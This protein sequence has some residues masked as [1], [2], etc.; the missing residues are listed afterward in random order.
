[1]KLLLDEMYSP[2]IAENL[3]D[4]GYDV[5]SAHERDDLAATDDQEIFRLMQHE[6][7]VIVTNNHRDFAPLAN[8]AL[9]ARESFSGLVFTSDRS[10]PRTKQTIP[11]M[12]ELLDE[13]LKQ[14]RNTEALPTAIA[15]L[16]PRR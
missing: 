11:V 5:I 10:L 4:L 12:V 3:R 6:E 13:L 9:Q 8:A 14:H 16:A 7:R 15:W 1:V 2:E